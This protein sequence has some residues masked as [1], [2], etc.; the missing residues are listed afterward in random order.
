[1]LPHEEGLL[2]DV[3]AILPEHPGSDQQLAVCYS[4]QVNLVMTQ[5][6]ELFQSS[7]KITKYLLLA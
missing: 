6:K 7:N 5:C 4:S 3:L 1:M 2:G